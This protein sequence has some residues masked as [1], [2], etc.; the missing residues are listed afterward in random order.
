M[1][2]ENQ[3]EDFF[4]KSN[5]S[6]SARIVWGPILGTKLMFLSGPQW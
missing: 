1:G 3:T 4:I 2:L 5:F 6:W